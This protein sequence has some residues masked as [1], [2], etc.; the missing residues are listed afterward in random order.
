[1]ELQIS[2]AP[3][4]RNGPRSLLDMCLDTAIR[5]IQHISSF[6]DMPI[7]LLQ[8]VLRAVKTAQQLHTLEQETDERIYEISPAHWKHLIQRDFKTLDAQYGWEPKD[9]KSWYK[10]YK[11]Y[12]TMHNQ[13]IEEATNA[14]MK[15]MEDVNG[16]RSSRQAKIISVPESRRLPLHYSQRQREGPKAGHWST[17]PRPKKT[18]IAKA[19]RQ[20]AAETNR[21]KLSSPGSRMPVRQSQITQAPIAMLNDARIGRQ[22]DA[23]ATI[24]NAPIRK[25]SEATNAS[26]RERKDRENRLLQ[27]KGKGVAKPAN[28]ISFSDDED[29]SFPSNDK[30]DLFGDDEPSSPPQGGGLSVE[31]LEAVVDRIVSPQKRPMA[32]PRSLLSAAPGANNKARMAYSPPKSSA[33]STSHPLASTEKT[34]TPIPS[35]GTSNSPP[36]PPANAVGP[37]AP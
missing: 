35:A 33:D 30:D 10:V 5:N 18:F 9:P 31:E 26:E 13:Q 22:F 32:R 25:A 24:V 34:S 14:F 21:L 7:H 1:M 16:Q 15:R 8:P 6:G 27:I 29:D 28:V 23:A 20:V 36:L 12:E 37:A 11:K 19:K 2:T 3:S 4:G 17:Q